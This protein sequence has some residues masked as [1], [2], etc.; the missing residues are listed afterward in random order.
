MPIVVTVILDVRS[1][2]SM[3]STPLPSTHS[4]MGGRNSRIVSIHPLTLFTIS[5]LQTSLKSHPLLIPPHQLQHPIPNTMQTV[6]LPMHFVQ[7]NVQ[8][9]HVFEKIAQSIVSNITKTISAPEKAT[10]QVHDPT[11]PTV[12]E[13]LTVFESEPENNQLFNFKSDTLQFG[14]KPPNFDNCLDFAKNAPE[15]STQ[16]I[17]PQQ[18]SSAPEFASEF[19][20]EGIP[21]GVIEQGSNQVP[22]QDRVTYLE[23]IQYQTVDEQSTC[24]V[25]EIADN[26]QSISPEHISTPMP[27]FEA[28]DSYIAPSQEINTPTPQAPVKGKEYNQPH[29]KKDMSKDIHND[30]TASHH[31]TKTAAEKSSQ[32]C[33]QENTQHQK[34]DNK[35]PDTIRE[36]PSASSTK[37]VHKEADSPSSTNRPIANQPAQHPQAT[38]CH[39]LAMQNFIAMAHPDHT[40]FG[41]NKRHKSRKHKK[42]TPKKKKHFWRILAR[43]FFGKMS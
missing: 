10:P 38:L 30:R 12:N 5:G 19:A 13:E 33:I 20:S 3:P 4:P 25:V 17:T 36:A 27:G 29:V 26:T 7:G 40:G 16:H 37:A 28:S 6:T 11:I 22:L 14:S 15:Q 8:Y 32:R 18:E 34:H 23:P 41:N 2:P 24:Q 39:G 1:A 9:A 43:L 35:R 42:G 31:P 21:I